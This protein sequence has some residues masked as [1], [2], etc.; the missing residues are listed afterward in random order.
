MSL[1]EKRK[2]FLVI[3]C[4]IKVSR[5]SDLKIVV[6]VMTYEPYRYF[7]EFIIHNKN[8]VDHI[9]VIDHRSS[10]KF[11]TL[12]IEGVT[13]VESNQVCQFQSEVTNVLIRDFR[14]YEKYDWIFV[15]DID[16]FL[17]FNRKI[18]LRDFLVRHESERVIAFNWRNGVGI[19]PTNDKEVK[20]YDSLINVSPLFVSNYINPT[21]KVAVNCN[22]LK[23]PFYFRTGA[24]EIV[25]PRQFVSTLKKVM[26]TSR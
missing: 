6:L 25:Q 1:Q 17:P 20:P 7:S 15:L 13:F 26:Y 12:H 5:V 2:R 19:Y 3:K 22:R 8:L 21:I 23:Y 9:Y 10:K 18:D 11:S 4:Q 14:L 16:E 24:H